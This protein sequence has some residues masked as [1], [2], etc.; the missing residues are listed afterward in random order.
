MKLHDTE[1]L[2]KNA[3]VWK[4]SISFHF[5]LLI[6]K[7]MCE[8]ANI[9][10]WTVEIVNFAC[11]LTIRVIIIYYNEI[12][13]LLWTRNLKYVEYVKRLTAHTP[14]HPKSF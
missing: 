4:C 11:F 5:A 2:I 9:V 6:N 12:S 14:K 7:L 10:E 13:L 1:I 3:F 8:T